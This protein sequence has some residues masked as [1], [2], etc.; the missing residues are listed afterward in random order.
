MGIIALKK[1]PSVGDIWMTTMKNIILGIVICLSVF[2]QAC[3]TVRERYYLTLA[4]AIRAGEIDRGW[5]PDCL[6]ESARQIHLLY[7]VE[8]TKTWC[9][10][11]F[12]SSDGQGFRKVVGR[13]LGRLPLKTQYISNARKAWWPDYLR[14]NID[15]QSIQKNGLRLYAVEESSAASSTMTVLFAINWEKQY[16]YFF[17]TVATG[18]VWPR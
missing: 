18:Y 16:G 11:I 14:G 8:S 13:E 1:S 15:I 7:S 17:R 2:M 9:A 6:P 4:D 10:F 5:I 12:S 3:G